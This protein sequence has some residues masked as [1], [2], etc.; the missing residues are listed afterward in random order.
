MTVLERWT[1]FQDLELLDQRMRRL[2]PALTG[3]TALAPAADIY[4]T[5]AEI[6]VELEVPGYEQKELEIE[7]TDRTLTV[8]GRRESKTETNGKTLKLHERLESSFERSFVLPHGADM[9]K[10][11]AVYG[12]GVLTLRVPKAPQPSPMRIPI[13]PA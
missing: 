12:K 2:F 6:V 8:A 10:L 11:T 7:V 3:A 13:E 1:P 9:A 5:A 4:E